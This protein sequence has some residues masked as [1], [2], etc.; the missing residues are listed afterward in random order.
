MFFLCVKVSD[1]QQLFFLLTA[2]TTMTIMAEKP[3]ARYATDTQ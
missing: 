3:M 1:D 2:A